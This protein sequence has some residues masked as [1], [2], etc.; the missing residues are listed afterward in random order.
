M[1][2]LND[3]STSLRKALSEIDSKWEDYPGLIVCGTHTPHDTEVIIEKI[4]IA[5]AVGRPFLGI[6]AGH[7]LAAIQYARDI[8]G[9]KDATSEEFGKGTYVVKKLPQ[10]KVGLHDGESWWNNYEVVIDWEKPEYFF[11]CQY[12]PEYQSSKDRPHPLLLSF[13][14]YAKAKK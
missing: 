5:R 13:I 14:N 11:T 8:L 12:H 4:R 6:C 10:L 3:F 7:Q 2:V 1:E 9:I